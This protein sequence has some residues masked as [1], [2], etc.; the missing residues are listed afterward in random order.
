M[1]ELVAK[2]VEPW[3]YSGCGKARDTFCADATKKAVWRGLSAR[4]PAFRD[5][6]SHFETSMIL[7]L[8]GLSLAW[9]ILESPRFD[10]GPDF[11]PHRKVEAGLSSFRFSSMEVTV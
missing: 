9:N 5:W 11:D 4:V 6:K 2:K 8:E 3:G 7:V 1:K 10:L